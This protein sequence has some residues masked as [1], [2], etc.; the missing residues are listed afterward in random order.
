MIGQKV[1]MDTTSEFS[2]ALQSSRNNLAA[3][4]PTFDKKECNQFYL[5]FGISTIEIP[6]H[7]VINTCAAKFLKD[8]F[9]ELKYGPYEERNIEIDKKYRNQTLTANSMSEQEI[10]KTLKAYDGTDITAYINSRIEQVDT[11]PMSTLLKELSKLEQE[12]EAKFKVKGT[13]VVGSTEGE[14]A[15]KVRENYESFMKQKSEANIE[16]NRK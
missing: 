13:D 6:V 12:F 9:G 15:R 7:T 10:I 14:F 5:T 2:V 1:F 16:K 8:T 11:I 3:H 4:L